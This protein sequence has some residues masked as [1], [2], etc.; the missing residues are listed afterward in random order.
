[1]NRWWIYQKERFPIFA[2]GTL[3]AAFSACA[4]AYSSLLGAAPSP[5]WQAYLTAF[6]VCFLMF[7]QNR[8]ADYFKDKE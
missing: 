6:I 2:H 1:M 3:I 8:N 7:L 4:V 5:P